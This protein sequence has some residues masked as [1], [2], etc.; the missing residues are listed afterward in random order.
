MNYRQGRL[1]LVYSRAHFHVQT[2]PVSLEDVLDVP[3]IALG[4]GSAILAAVQRAYRSQGRQFQSRF[5]VSGFD[6]MLALLRVGLGGG[7]TPPAMLPACKLGQ[8]PDCSAIHAACHGGPYM[9]VS[10]NTHA[11][12]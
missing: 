8:T 11:H 4:K 2:D 3:L 12:P 7:L 5:V 6:T 9:I 1:V 10:V